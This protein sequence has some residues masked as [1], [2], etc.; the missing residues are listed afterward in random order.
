MWQEDKAVGVDLES[1][2]TV[3]GVFPRKR[4]NHRCCIIPQGPERPQNATFP[5]SQ[6]P[7]ISFTGLLHVGHLSRSL[8]FVNWVALVSSHRSNRSS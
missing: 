2:T 4:V 3:E 8:C 5:L 6:L 1:Y 7:S